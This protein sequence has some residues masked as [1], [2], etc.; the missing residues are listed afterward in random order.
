MNQKI[1]QSTLLLMTLLLMCM[2]LLTVVGT[3]NFD[4][5]PQPFILDGIMDDVVLVIGEDAAGEDYL[6]GLNILSALY[7][8]NVG[9]TLPE[10][11]AEAAT[12]SE[13]IKIER[14]GNKFNYG[15]DI[16]DVHSEAYD[17]D[18]V[19][20]ILAT[21]T[22][23]DKKGDKTQTSKYTQNLQFTDGVGTLVF[24]QPSGMDANTYLKLQKNEWLYTYTLS[25]EKPISYST[26]D[27]S[28]DLKGNN[29][30]I[31]GRNYTITEATDKSGALEK[32]TLA[33]SDAVVWLTEDQPYV[34]GANTITLI[35]V[36][37]SGTSCFIQVDSSAS[38]VKEDKTSTVGGLTLSVLDAVALNKKSKDLD[39]CKITLE[40]LQIELK[41]GGYASVNDENM[42][43][44]SV[45]FLGSAGSWEGIEIKYRIGKALT[46]VNS[47][48]VYLVAGDAW[49]DPLFGKW[50]LTYD[51][52]TADY[53]ELY[54]EAHNDDATFRFVNNDGKEVTIPYLYDKTNGK[55]MLGTSTKRPLLLPGEE[56][57]ANPEG[58]MLFYTTSR[59]EVHILEITDLSCDVGG[60]NRI[61]VKDRTYNTLVA[62]DKEISSCN[63]ELQ[64]ISLRSLG[65]IQVEV[66][67]SSIVYAD[68]E[69][70]GNGQPKSYYGGSVTFSAGSVSFKEKAGSEQALSTI[71]FNLKWNAGD[72]EILLDTVTDDGNSISWVKSTP[73]DSSTKW[74]VTDK[75]TLLEYDA[76]DKQWL[77]L[78]APQKDAY[79]DVFLTPLRATITPGSDTVIQ[80]E[81]KEITAVSDSD[82]LTMDKHMLVVGGP[83]AN[84]V[85][86]EI[87]GNPENCEEGFTAGQA[88]LEFFSRN[89]KT[90]LLVAGYTS[91]DTL[92]A[93]YG[94][95]QY[96]NLGLSGNAVTLQVNGIDDVSVVSS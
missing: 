67:P 95:S 83:C 16:Y 25:F 15:D 1:K 20:D 52:I 34:V 60:K 45:I 40:S 54:F 33:R 18:D 63:G 43:G 79:A 31:Q 50:K 22:F 55:F 6:A 9:L 10:E 71:K 87:L 11:S 38:W 24:A 42:K 37:G 92:A 4:D 46:G 7:A 36:D 29:I 64:T 19:A 80:V 65:S 13:G 44:S 26:H 51:G 89:G 2:S 66:S 73:S 93:A 27:V 41:S 23:N 96:K 94:L 91:D 68:V 5:Y 75:G 12:V 21:G 47:D 48:D 85:A 61:T 8:D 82:A 69:N 77:R 74:W 86:A 35:D 17:A 3:D 32:L 70:Y 78:F 62:Q 88:T 39:R 84:S 14:S 57:D 72:K 49:T 56:Y 53:E 30:V 76:D 81:K 90:I 59:G 58:V 28:A